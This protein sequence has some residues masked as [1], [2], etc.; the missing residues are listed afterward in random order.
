M[1]K[2][3]IGIA[4][5]LISL[6][7]FSQDIGEKI[8]GDSDIKEVYITYTEGSDTLIMD[9]YIVF[10]EATY[11]DINAQCYVKNSAY[12]VVDEW[13]AIMKI[14]NIIGIELKEEES[15]VL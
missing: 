3:I 10:I 9:G 7:G 14:N 6:V 5:S 11:R 15:N 12:H 13:F 4:L 1:K 8:S 2:L